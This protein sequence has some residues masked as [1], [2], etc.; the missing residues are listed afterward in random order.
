M[1][2]SMQPLAWSLI[3][4]MQPMMRL[5]TLSFRVSESNELRATF[6]TGMRERHQGLESVSADMKTSYAVGRHRLP[7]LQLLHGAEQSRIHCW[8]LDRSPAAP[9]RKIVVT[10]RLGNAYTW[11]QKGISVK[12]S[13]IGGDV[14]I[15]IPSR[16]RSPS[17]I[18]N[19]VISTRKHQEDACEWRYRQSFVQDRL[20]FCHVWRKLA[21]R[22]MNWPI[23]EE[24]ALQTYHWHGT[25]CVDFVLPC[26]I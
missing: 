24:T 8:S 20:A 7:L 13:L 6:A 17:P 12:M 11:A 4:D 2:T 22:D 3:T 5:S 10:E 9:N 25:P 21:S 14:H 23:F 18:S 16:A 26:P 19:D 1:L 15:V